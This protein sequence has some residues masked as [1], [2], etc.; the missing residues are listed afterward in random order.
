MPRPTHAYRGLAQ[1]SRLQVAALVMEQPGISLVELSEKTG[2]HANT[3]RDH[4]RVL[5]S[6]GIIRSE[7]EHR[8]MRGRPRALFYPMDAGV[9]NEAAQRRIEQAKKHGDLLGRIMP[10]T[11]SDPELALEPDAVHQLD[12]LYEHLDEVGLDPRVAER[13]LEVALRPC[14]FHTLVDNHREALCRVHEGL[15]REVLDRAGGPVEIDRLLPLVSAHRCELVLRLAAAPEGAAAP[16]GSVG[17][18]ATA[19]ATATAISEASPSGDD[20]VCAPRAG[21]R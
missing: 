6:E 3:L 7:V 1:P 20:D 5:T 14:A 13:D 16:G 4:V 17:R 10:E 12:A 18:D 19:T 8:A 2:L 9:E 11:E 21:R 15:I